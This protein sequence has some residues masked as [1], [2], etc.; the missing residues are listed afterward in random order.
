M[1]HL[2]PVDESKVEIIKGTYC[3]GM[4]YVNIYYYIGFID[5]NGTACRLSE[6]T[7]CYSEAKD[8]FKKKQYAKF[9]TST[10]YQNGLKIYTTA[11]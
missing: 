3:S 6:P 10:E 9:V 11:K 7:F 2:I 5:E 4:H 8:K 1:S